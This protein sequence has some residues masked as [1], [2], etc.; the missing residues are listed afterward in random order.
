MELSEDKRL[1]KNNCFPNSIFSIDI[2]L[3]SGKG[4]APK[5]NSEEAVCLQVAAKNKSGI[6]SKTL[7]LHF[8]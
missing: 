3:S 8:I 6:I 2:G 1:S 4:I 7:L 5:T